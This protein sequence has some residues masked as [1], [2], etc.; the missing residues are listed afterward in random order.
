MRTI[1]EAWR[2]ALGNALGLSV[3]VLAAASSTADQASDHPQGVWGNELACS[4]WEAGEPQRPEASVY[5]V[6]EHW[7]E[8]YLLACYFGD[9]Q[10]H[11]LDEHRW[12]TTIVC[13]EDGIRPYSLTMVAGE[14]DQLSFIWQH[15][16]DDFVYEV[17][18]LMACGSPSDR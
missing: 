18:P 3:T 8:R 15:P 5:N 14:N 10:P 12:Q 7:L 13:G 11:R 1:K 9:T 2:F 6:S 4:V 17:G 16:D